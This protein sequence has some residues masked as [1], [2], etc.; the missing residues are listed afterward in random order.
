MEDAV[1]D[2]ASGRERGG[3]SDTKYAFIIPARE[4]GHY[5]GRSLRYLREVREEARIPFCVIVVDGG[6]RDG[7]VKDAKGLADVVISDS[8]LARRSI[9][10]ARN[11]GAALV[12]SPF[13]FHTDADVLIPDLPRLLMHAERAFEDPAVVAVTTRLMPYPWD[14]TRTDVFMHRLANAIIRL[15]LHLGAFLARGEC[16]I[17]RRE[18]FCKVGGYNGEIIAGEDCDLFRRLNRIGRIVYLRD[19]C[20]HH[21]PRR[22]REVGYLRIICIYIREG[23]SLVLRRRSY[24]SEWPLVR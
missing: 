10:H 22:F 21:S 4:E 14:A 12:S 16:Q 6:S 2:G 24:L 19:Y 1:S 8:G 15:T 23:L 20:V 9:G 3:C 18:A 11:V 13:L 7:T 17:V 5:I